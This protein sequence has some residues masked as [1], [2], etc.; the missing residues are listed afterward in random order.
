MI[1]ERQA[2]AAIQA[3][4]DYIKSD[5]PAESFVIFIMEAGSVLKAFYKMDNMTSGFTD[6]GFQKARASVLFNNPTEVFSQYAQPG[7]PFYSIEFSNGDLALF[8]GG[9]PVFDSSSDLIAAVGVSG[10]MDAKNDSLVAHVIAQSLTQGNSSSNVIPIR[11]S[12][13]PMEYITS[14]QAWT[15]LQAAKSSSTSFSSVGVFNPSG[16]L[17]MFIREDEALLGTVDLCMFKAR[18]STK[19]PLPSEA[20][21]QYSLPNGGIYGINN[22]INAVFVAGALPIPTDAGSAGVVSVSGNFLTPSKDEV[23]A[24][25]GVAAYYSAR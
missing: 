24:Q 15:V 17:R 18:A 6:V 1:T 8:P 21:M 12:T 14:Y 7:G 4:L 16:D 9:V 22:L 19:V 13:S 3:G 23:A 2:Y 10:S 5:H 11:S 25:A 20:L